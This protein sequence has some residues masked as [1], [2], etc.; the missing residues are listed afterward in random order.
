MRTYSQSKY[1][2]KHLAL[3]QR[4]RSVWRDESAGGGGKQLGIGEAHKYNFSNQN[5]QCQKETPSSE[6]EYP[7]KVVDGKGTRSCFQL[8]H[9]A[10]FYFLILACRR[11]QLNQVI[12]P[13]LYDA[14]FDEALEYFVELLE[15]RR[16]FR[17]GPTK[18][19]WKEIFPGDMHL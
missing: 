4:A 19:T 10:N 12:H 8:C 5:K 18:A 7:L 3:I 15:V 2:S 13:L 11:W 14:R 6:Q 17:K 9:G 1:S 16:V